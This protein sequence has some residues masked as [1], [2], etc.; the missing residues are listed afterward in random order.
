MV[1]LLVC[2]KGTVGP[3]EGRPVPDQKIYLVPALFLF[4]PS[5]PASQETNYITRRMVSLVSSWQSVAELVG[6]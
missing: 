1:V 4:H 5:L 6:D 3:T 2:W